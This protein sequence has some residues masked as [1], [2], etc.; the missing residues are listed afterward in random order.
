MDDHLATRPVRWAERALGDQ[1]V[2]ARPLTGGITSTMLALTTADG[3]RAVLRLMTNEPWRTHGAELTTREH[4]TQLLLAD[5]DIPAPRSIALDA[6]GSEAGEAAH[7]MSMVPGTVDLSRTS[8]ADLETLARTLV[9]I[10]ALLP[11][12]RP[13]TY[14]SW[15]F[16]AKYV[17]PEWSREPA[18]WERAFAICDH[19]PP[20]YEGTFL[21]R[22]FAP[23]NVLWTGPE[24]TGVVDWVETSWGPPWLDVAHFRNNLV[25]TH[26]TEVADRFSTTYTRLTGREPQP[27]FD[28]LDIIG[29]LP[30]P[31]RVPFVAD[32]AK[33]R[34]L[35][36]HLLTLL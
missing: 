8:D 11:R 33:Q 32:P 26:G 18:A 23:R 10:H 21:H 20:A 6:D 2:E 5:T 16:P 22:D 28:V 14:Q 36:V 12:V 17:V 31:G 25:L 4:E 15:A 19:V 1:V 34:R 29:L 35:E 3:E 27:Y 13:R 7:L 9:D 30:A 24:I